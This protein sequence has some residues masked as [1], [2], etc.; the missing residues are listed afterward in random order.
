MVESSKSF[1]STAI[2]QSASYLQ[3]N[4]SHNGT[5]FAMIKNLE[6]GGMLY[7]YGQ[8]VTEQREK[9]AKP[10]TPLGT[11]SDTCDLYRAQFVTVQ[12]TTY[13]VVCTMQGCQIYNSNLSRKLFDFAANESG[14]KDYWFTCA[15]AAEYTDFKEQFIAVAST[16]GKV[17]CVE[18]QP[19][20]VTFSQGTAF[21]CGSDILDTA[22]DSV[23]RLILLA[24]A[25]GDCLIIKSSKDKEWSQLHKLPG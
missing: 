2:A 8:E 23:T 18:V 13:L 5:A 17:C 21:Q 20:G 6:R 15:C 14:K 10:V 3:N 11:R 24:Q 12:A 19:G 1:R 9:D 25:N 4:L 7:V 22:F 16:E